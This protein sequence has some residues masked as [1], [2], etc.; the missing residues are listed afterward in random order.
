MGKIN[1]ETTD[2]DVIKYTAQVMSEMDPTGKGVIGVQEFERWY[3]AQ[4]VQEVV[5]T[6][7]ICIRVVWILGIFWSDRMLVFTEPDPRRAV[8]RAGCEARPAV[9]LLPARSEWHGCP[10]EVDPRRD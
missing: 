9:R 5:S 7:A 6:Q 2:A 1:D 4:P 10:R 8:R 3:E